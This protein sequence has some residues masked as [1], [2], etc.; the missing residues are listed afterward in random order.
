MSQLRVGQRVQVDLLGMRLPHQED[1]AVDCTIVALGPGV[2]TVR[3]DGAG[4]GFSEVTV[5]PERIEGW[6]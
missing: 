1:G 6:R 3:L 5:S 4:R 2:V